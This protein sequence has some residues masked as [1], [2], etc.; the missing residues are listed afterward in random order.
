[1]TNVSMNPELGAT[2][3]KNWEMP[4]NLAA[5]TARWVKQTQAGYES[6]SY[7]A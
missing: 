2:E 5:V 7:V 4:L 3:S 6:R 1:M